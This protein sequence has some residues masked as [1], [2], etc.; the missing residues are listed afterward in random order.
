MEPR[1]RIGIVGAGFIAGVVAQAILESESCV[2]AAVASRTPASAQRLAEQFAIFHVF[3]TWTE[4]ISSGTVDAV[5]VATPT[6]AEEEICLAAASAGLHVLADKPFTDASSVQRIGDACLAS[7]VAFL[8]ATHFVHHPRHRLLKDTFV[9]R[10][11]AARCIHTSFFFPISDRTNIRVRPDQEPTGAVGDMAWYSMRAVVEFTPDG[12]RVTDAKGFLVRDPETNGVI[13]TCGVL[14]LSDGT[15][16]VW[17][18]GYDTGAA[19]QSLAV[20][21]EQGMISQDDFVLD[22]AGGFNNPDPRHEVGFLERHGAVP[23]RDWAAI[24]T[25][26]PKRQAVHMMDNFAALCRAGDPEAVRRS[27]RVSQRTQTLVDAIWAA[28]QDTRG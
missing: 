28:S 20:Q 2:V 14:R 4:L 25:P 19:V 16:S 13:R 10:I 8:D 1:L 21:G 12:A 11:G 6:I 27:I 15:L 22:W 24:P 7:G 9:E 3:E 23:P 18:A 17:E 26:S 5:Y